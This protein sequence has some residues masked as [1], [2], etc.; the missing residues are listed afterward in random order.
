MLKY[1]MN[2]GDSFKQSIFL[3]GASRNIG[4]NKTTFYKIRNNDE[5]MMMENMQ[6]LKNRKKLKILMIMIVVIF[7]VKRG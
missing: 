2:F 3:Y 6:S 1:I 5:T 4:E 7:I